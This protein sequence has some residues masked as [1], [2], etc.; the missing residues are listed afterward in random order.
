MKNII[1]LIL[2]TS[3]TI[4][5]ISCNNQP[6]KQTPSMNQDSIKAVIIDLQNKMLFATADPAKYE[7][8]SEDSMMSMYDRAFS[9]SAHSL[10]HD[11]SN[12]NTVSPHDYKFRLFSNTALLTFLQTF[13][14]VINGDSVFQNVRVMKTFVFNNGQWK[15]ASMCTSL[16]QENYFKP[17]AEN[18]QNEY[19]DYA[20]VYQ[21]KDGFADTVFVK[22]GKLYE[23]FTNEEPTLNFPVSDSEYMEKHDLSRVVY[24]NR[25]KNGKVAF[26]TFIRSDGQRFRVPKMK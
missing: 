14:E 11:L 1:N 2:I 26:Y 21:W 16:Q 7:S 9:S 24:N 13:Y 6:V 8:Y 17:V 20:G 12:G 25:D 3:V 15:Q 10:S 4:C 18:H 5:L 19:N 22:D 23:R